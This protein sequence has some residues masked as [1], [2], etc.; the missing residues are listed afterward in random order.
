MRKTDGNSK[1]DTTRRQDMWE[2]AQKEASKV[3]TTEF[4]KLSMDGQSSEDFAGLDISPK[5]K[6]VKSTDDQPVNELSALV[7]EQ[8]GVSAADNSKVSR[9]ILPI[10]GLVVGSLCLATAI[11]FLSFPTGTASDAPANIAVAGEP[12][13]SDDAGITVVTKQSPALPSAVNLQ[14][15]AAVIPVE[16]KSAAVPTSPVAI[17]RAVSFTQV[18][19]SDFQ[20]VSGKSLAQLIN[21][22]PAFTPIEGLPAVQWQ[23]KTCSTCH[24]W[25]RATLCKQGN[26]YMKHGLSA[27]ARTE[28]P[29]G[30]GFKRE[31][32]AWADGG[33]Q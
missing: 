21:G 30:G 13:R 32:M 5:F 22:K 23:E 12:S 1:S 17:K 9:N 24:S 15:Q 6:P 33:C 3:K 28:H 27:V 11:K 19:T 14:E 20:R 31:V 25:D 18:I 8:S 7:A 4:G 2:A 29:Y 10:M 26:F 16:V